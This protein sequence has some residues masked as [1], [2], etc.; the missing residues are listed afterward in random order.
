[1]PV[2]DGHRAKQSGLVRLKQGKFGDADSLLSRALALQESYTTGPG[3]EMAA[4]L[5]RLAEVRRK[6]HRLSDAE[7]L[8][9]RAIAMQSYR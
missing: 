8:H 2:S 5:D 3:S 7:E 1:M 4:T 9:H 6:E